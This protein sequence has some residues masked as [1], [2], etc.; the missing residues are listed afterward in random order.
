MPGYIERLDKE[1]DEITDGINARLE[2]AAEEGRDLTEEE[3]A[4]IE[5]DDARRADVERARE[6][7]TGLQERQGR[8]NQL[9]SRAPASASPTLI[10]RAGGN[11]GGDEFSDADRARRGLKM[12]GA[13][14]GAFAYHQRQALIERS[15]DS[16]EWM[17][18]VGDLVERATAHQITSENPGLIPS[19][20]VGPVI[21][22][23]KGNRR[24]IDSLGD[25]NP[26]PAGSFDR[27]KVTQH[28]SVTKQATEKSE[29]ASQTLK[30]VKFPV[31]LETYAGHLNLSKQDVRW[32]S[33][34]LLDIVYADFAKVYRKQTDIAACADFVTG[35][36]VTVEGVVTSIAA[37]DAWLQAAASAVLAAADQSPDTIWLSLDMRNALAS[38]R[39]P[40]GEKPYDLPIAGE[41]GD[42]E[43][44]IPVTDPNFAAG[45]MIVGV[46]EYAE[47]WED[48]EGFLT[49]EEPSVLGQ[50]VGYAGYLD[51][52][53]PEPTAFA[54]FLLDTTP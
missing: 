34:A 3:N 13:T 54:K 16:I 37:V 33:P 12:L 32:T 23:L 27:P 48:L 24:F 25:T 22:M 26:A 46:A 36:T 11:G 18:R 50:L 41:G 9:R 29:T 4:L 39:T 47:A 45:T 51:T 52:I 17:Q 20:I 42:V 7:Y 8:V 43:G 14:P 28:T 5:R 10:D 30:V 6:H 49:V 38:L 53:V 1:F 2:R 15:R 19:P 40:L 35:A 21:D 31:A 44:L